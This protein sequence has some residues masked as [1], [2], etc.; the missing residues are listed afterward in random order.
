MAYSKKEI[1]TLFNK[2]IESIEDGNS[3]RSTLREDGMPHKN[4]FYKWVDEDD[5][6]KAQY[7]R[8]MEDRAEKI[9]EDIIEISDDSGLDVTLDSEGKYSING[10]LVQRARLRVD[11]RKW[12]L[13]KMQPKKYGDKLDLTTAGEK[14]VSDRMTDE[15][16]DAKIKE[17]YKKDD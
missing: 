13:G 3:L 1:E 9:F 15:E 14:I 11:S 16:L 17:L 10:E 4:S 7:A 2:I 12:F 5:E 8:A 6:K